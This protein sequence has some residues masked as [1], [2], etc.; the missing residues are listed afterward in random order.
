M[1][2]FQAR[3]GVVT[4]SEFAT[5]MTKGRGGGES[6]TRRTYLLKLIG[7][8]LTGE[9]TDGFTNMH[10]ERG[11][12]MEREARD[13][14]AMLRDVEPREVGFLRRGRVGA[15]P[16]ALVGDDGLLEI[17]TKLPHLH[18]E[19]LLAGELPKEHRPQSQG[20]MWVSGRKWLDFMS[21]WPGLP[22]FLVRVTRDE[23]YIAELSTAV[24]AF[25]AEMDEGIARVRSCG[26]S[27]EAAL[28]ASVE[29]VARRRA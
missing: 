17:K 28:A 5:V 7:E 3:L 2:W 1:D 26:T 16:D 10:M 25:L 20:Q 11:H 22:P 6:K 23:A 4:A 8:A 15:S 9:R 21:Y 24:N 27:L 14:Y 29:A 19:L 18:L 13:L 12:E